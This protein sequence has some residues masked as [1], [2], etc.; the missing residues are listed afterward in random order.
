MRSS[1]KTWAIVGAI[2]LLPQMVFA[3]PGQDA[4]TSS[5]TTQIDF[6]P[7]KN[8]V[9]LNG[10]T[11]AN[12]TGSVKALTYLTGSSDPAT[13]AIR[14]INVALGFLGTISLV[15]MLYAGFIWFT[16]RDNEEEVKRAKQI[17][18]GAVTGLAITMSAYGIS[19]LVYYLAASAAGDPTIV[20]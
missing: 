13:I 15:F 18:T 2:L 3:T 14:L 20:I 6:D 1:F 7:S 11:V 17:I 9:G 8:P 19:S 10:N 4:L 12:S 5:G 16:A